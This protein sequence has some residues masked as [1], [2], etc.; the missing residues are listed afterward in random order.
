MMKYT[1]KGLKRQMT[2]NIPDLRHLSGKAAVFVRGFIEH[3]FDQPAY[4]AKLRK[5]QDA[6]VRGVTELG[7]TISIPYVSKL[8]KLLETSGVVEK[9]RKGKG[10]EVTKGERFF[11]LA[12]YLKDSEWGQ[13]LEREDSAETISARSEFLDLMGQKKA[14]RITQDK[15]LP[16]AAYQVAIDKFKSG[17]YDMVFVDRTI[18]L[19]VMDYGDYI[20]ELRATLDASVGE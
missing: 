8:T 1:T 20:G 16:K 11:D 4:T 14:V 5:A 15:P 3:V 18:D 19:N 2:E 9:T 7:D 13:M 10:Y 6:G 12:K 17:K